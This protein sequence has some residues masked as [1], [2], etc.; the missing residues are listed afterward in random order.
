MRLLIAGWQKTRVAPPSLRQL[1]TEIQVGG[2]TPPANYRFRLV[3]VS[4]W[5]EHSIF[6]GLAIRAA[7][8][9]Y[10][11][12]FEDAIGESFVGG[13][14]REELHELLYEKLGLELSNEDL[15]QSFNRLI[16]DGRVTIP[17]IALKPNELAGAGLRYLPVEG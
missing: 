9:H 13:M 14:D 10:Q 4:V 7:S 3:E 5:T 17:E 2:Q 1:G 15:D 8:E 6:N 11:V 12:R 16:R